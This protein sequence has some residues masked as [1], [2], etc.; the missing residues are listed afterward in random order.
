ML[1]MTEDQRVTSDR[2]R[3]QMR[4]QLCNCATVHKV[5]MSKSNG[6]EDWGAM[7]WADCDMM[8]A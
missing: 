4:K 2:M 7:T 8:S 6:K 3:V 1:E 5:C